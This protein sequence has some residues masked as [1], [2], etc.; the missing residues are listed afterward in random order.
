MAHMALIMFL[1]GC[2]ALQTQTEEAGR[3]S[4]SSAS[5]EDRLS[6]EGIVWLL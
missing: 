2:A 4:L 5:R 1:L 6:W 3:V